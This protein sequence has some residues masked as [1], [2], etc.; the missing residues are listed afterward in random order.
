MTQ[1]LDVEDEDIKAAIVALLS[2]VQGDLRKALKSWHRNKNVK[3]RHYL[4]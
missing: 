4:K 2:Y 3:K 1:M